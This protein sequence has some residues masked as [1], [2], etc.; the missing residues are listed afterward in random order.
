[1]KLIDDL[2]TIDHG[3]GRAPA[4]QLG[5]EAMAEGKPEIVLAPGLS[6]LIGQAVR[7]T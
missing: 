2:N 4:G 1:V 7:G 3:R 5:G 6:G